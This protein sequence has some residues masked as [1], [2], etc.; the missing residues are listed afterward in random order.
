L[1]LQVNQLVL[2]LLNLLVHGCAAAA[3]AAASHESETNSRKS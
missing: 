3:A 2:Q 1:S